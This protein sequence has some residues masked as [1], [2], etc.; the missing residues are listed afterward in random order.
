MKNGKREQFRCF[1]PLAP[2]I[3]KI[4]LLYGCRLE[5]LIGPS[6]EGYV[7]RARHEAIYRIYMNTDYTYA[8]IGNVFGG[9]SS[10]TIFHAFTKI[11]SR[12]GGYK[13]Y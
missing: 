5:D 6:R 9:R 11:A 10:A 2:V 12:K 4:A 7:V 8:Q 3:K 13:C 1:P